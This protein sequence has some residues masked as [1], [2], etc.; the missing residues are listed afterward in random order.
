MTKTEL[1]ESGSALVE[2]FC[3]ANSIRIPVRKIV[4]KIAWRFNVCAFYRPEQ[5]TICVEKCAHI[6]TANRAWSYPGYV[7]DRTPHGVMAH[8]LGHHVD[9]LKSTVKGAYGGD[10]SSQMR[11]ASGEKKLTNYCPNDWEWFAEMFRLFVTNSSLLL[12]VRPKTYELMLAAG[13]E[14][15]VRKHWSQVLSDAPERTIAQA[16]AKCV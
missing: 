1:L 5:I 7:I 9:H 13:L 16:K 8:E 12:A 10:F 6:G 15:V 4:P 14:P 11:A 2:Q 3:V